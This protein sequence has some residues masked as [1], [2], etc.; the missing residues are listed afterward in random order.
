MSNIDWSGVGSNI[1]TGIVNG[2]NNFGHYIWDTLRGWAENAWEN[3]KAFFR[4]GSPSKLM[5]ETIG[6]WIPLGIAE[7]I[8]DEGDAVSDAL[9]DIT[10]LNNIPLDYNIKPSF[11]TN[12]SDGIMGNRSTSY[13]NQEPIV[14]NI[15]P[16]ESQDAKDIAR[17]V[18]RILTLWQRQKQA[19]FA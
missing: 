14:I 4:I 15:Y 13:A 17:E 12:S 11:Y 19:V 18:E 16:T 8:E 3:V 5:E 1:I 10:N 2:I 6:K 7:G 9:A